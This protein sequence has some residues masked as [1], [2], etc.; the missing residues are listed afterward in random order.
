VWFPKCT[1]E[2]SLT[3]QSSS[4]QAHFTFELGDD[5][6]GL[7]CC[8]QHKFLCQLL[9]KQACVA[10]DSTIICVGRDIWFPISSSSSQLLEASIAD[11]ALLQ[12]CFTLILGDNDN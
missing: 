10:S 2:A 9:E 1:F 8:L 6:K 5:D 11:Q 3:D 12:A 7:W 4:P